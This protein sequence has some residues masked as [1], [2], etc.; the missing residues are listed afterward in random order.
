MRTAVS[1]VYP[2]LVDRANTKRFR[3][4]FW[5]ETLDDGS[6][7]LQYLQVIDIEFHK[8]IGEEAADKELTVWPH[9]T[10]N[11]AIN[12]LYQQPLI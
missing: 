11:K 9:I 5:L 10:L 6:Q 2:F 1:R 8:R 7:Q 3:S 4:D 12:T